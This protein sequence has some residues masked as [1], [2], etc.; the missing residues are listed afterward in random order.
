MGLRSNL[1]QTFKVS[2]T[3]NFASDNG[4]GDGLAFVLQTEG[5]T[6]KGGQGGGIGYSYGN[7]GMSRRDVSYISFGGIEF[8]TYDHSV[9]SNASNQRCGLHHLS[10]QKNGL[11]D[12]FNS[13]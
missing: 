5:A 6:G 10:I 4:A 8:D 13:S 7:E 11:M 2:F 12:A 1:N 3:A 9:P